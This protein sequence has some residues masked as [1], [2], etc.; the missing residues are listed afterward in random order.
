MDNHPLYDKILNTDD[1]VL[2]PFPCPEWED[3][4]GGEKL[5]IRI[6][7]GGERDALELSVTGKDGK[8]SNMANF[9]ARFVALV[10]RDKD[11][12]RIFNDGQIGALSRKSSV[13]LE[14]AK[15]QGWKLND[16]GDDDIEELEK[17]SEG[18]PSD[19]SG[20]GSPISGDAQ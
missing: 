14:R 9:R 11:G 20:S 3:A 12:K 15:E 4:L 16:M 17:N 8:S 6:F 7:S 19:A 10:L 5:F 1:L 2:E 13:V 18:G